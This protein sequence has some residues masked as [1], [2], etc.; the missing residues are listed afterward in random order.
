MEVNTSPATTPL[1]GLT[2]V[3]TSSRNQPVT[4]SSPAVWRRFWTCRTNSQI[5]NKA[6]RI[7]SRHAYT[8]SRIT[9]LQDCISNSV[10]P[11]TLK[12]KVK[13]NNSCSSELSVAWQKI[14]H[15]TSISFLKLLVQE[16]QSNLTE[17]EQLYW[18]HR[19]KLLKYL[20]S[21][22]VSNHG[23]LVYDTMLYVNRCFDQRL[24]EVASQRREYHNNKLRNLI[25][26]KKSYVQNADTSQVH[27]T[28]NI[29][30]ISFDAPDLSEISLPDLSFYGDDNFQ[31]H[32]SVNDSRVLHDSM[33]TM[34]PDISF[35]AVFPEELQ[36][37]PINTPD[38]STISKKN[39]KFIKRSRYKRLM[40]RSARKPLPCLVNNFSDMNF[41]I[42]RIEGVLNKSLSF[43]PTP[44]KMDITNMEAGLQKF[45]R[46]LFWREYWHDTPQNSDQ[47]ISTINSNNTVKQVFFDKTK[48]NL[49]PIS[50]N[51]PAALSR[52]AD[53]IHSDVLGSPHRKYYSN[54]SDNDKETIDFLIKAQRDRIITIK[55]NDKTGGCSILNTIDYIKSLDNLL[56]DTY[57]DKHNVSHPLYEGD[58]S[59]E[60]LKLHW[61]MIKE[62]VE[63]GVRLGYIHKKDVP[64]LYPESP[65]A[66]RLYGLVKDH[67]SKDKWSKSGKIP[68]LRPVVSMSGA[69]TEGLSHW[70][71]MLSKKEVPKLP[72]YLEDTRHLLAIIEETN[73]KSTQ[74]AGAIPVVMDITNMYGNIPWDEGLIAFEEAIADREN[75][76]I[77]TDFIMEVLK[78]V[79]SCNVFEFNAV[80]FIQLFG[81]AMGAKIAPT[82][83]CIFMGYLEAKMLSNYKGLLTKLWKR[84]IDDIFFLWHGNKKQLLDFITYLNSCHPTIKFKCKEGEHYDFKTRSV[85]F[86]DTTIFIDDNGYLQ[87]TLYT[88]PNMKVQYLLPSSCH[89]GHISQNIPYS[90]AYRLRRIESINNNFVS[91]LS[92]LKEKLLS[93]GYKEKVI[94]PAFDRVKALERSDTLIKTVK[95]SNQPVVL[96]LKYHPG[97]PKI[98][99][100]LKKHHSVLIKDPQMKEIFPNPLIVSYQRPK[101]LREILIRA[102]LPPFRNNTRASNPRK[103]ITKGFKHCNKRADCCLCPRSQERDTHECISFHNVFPIQSRISC[104]D[105]FVVY[106]ITCNKESGP[107]AL[108]PPQYIGSTS[109]MAKTRLSGHLGTITQDCH[110]ETT[111]TI[112]RHFRLPGHSAANLVFLP[113]EKVFSQ[114]TGVLA[115]RERYWINLYG[116]VGSGLNVNHT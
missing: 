61:Q 31:S 91:N 38:I 114:D 110:R 6:L 90:L 68:P 83:A 70:V 41:D 96:S 109:K 23:K 59:H 100:I 33:H 112:G 72:S 1:I 82:F 50:H 76:D 55:P 3:Q 9:F 66:G 54:V 37:V 7:G 94:N 35:H 21:D 113:F 30:D 16:E 63:K 25:Q 85:D 56:N 8:K 44:Q 86:L 46:T 89:P 27:D 108:N 51:K 40:R 34:P 99:A 19:N 116:A 57:L 71:D 69:N 36:D 53:A 81:A 104:T 58:V 29:S 15:N 43:V 95:H 22:T 5:Y 67:S 20:N 42:N 11:A 98:S 49:P 75:T 24:H 18:H 74:P 111:C 92:V 60:T 73:A 47:S 79:L 77:P 62:V 107:C 102:K 26:K 105:S 84:Y 12:C 88:K 80:L 93:R 103:C 52:C 39:R 13:H 97:L 32:D 115:A 45:R 2:S 48:T 101:N 14:E 65:K 17:I 10:V 87:T 4:P 64:F 78:L 28:S 106:S